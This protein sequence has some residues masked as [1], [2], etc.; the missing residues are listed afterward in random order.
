MAD[1]AFDLDYD[2]PALASHEMDVRDL[3]PALLSAADLFQE[4]NRI[5]RPLD[6]PVSVNVRA[7]DSGSFVVQLML[8][9]DNTVRG[10][11]SDDATAAV[12]LSGL[13]RLVG[14]LIQ[15][16]RHRQGREVVEVVEE[17]AESGLSTVVYND[18]TRL[19]VPT[20]ALQLNESFVV[21]R[22][23][24]EVVRPLGREGIESLTVRE[25]TI[26]IAHVTSSDMPAFENIGTDTSTRHLDERKTVREADLRVRRLSFQ[27]ERKW[28]FSDGQSEFNADMRDEL[29][30]SQ[31]ARNAY[32]IGARDSLRCVVET[33]QWYD[34]HGELHADV[35]IARVVALIE[36]AAGSAAPPPQLSLDDGDE[37]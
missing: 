26:E 12:N 32:K 24:R 33:T 21:R 1:V 14:N 25:D 11:P 31:L 34:E 36:T 22:N 15:L 23:L 7:L 28:R 5:L 17:E 16:A 30:M 4:A 37:I 13:L 35:R 3:A 18:Q 20:Q 29:F 27:P 19:E 2:G 8:L 10:L 9:Y 6:P